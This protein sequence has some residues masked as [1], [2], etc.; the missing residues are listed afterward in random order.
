MHI[1]VTCRNE[2]NSVVTI[3]SEFLRIILDLA[4]KE[5]LGST[6]PN[7]SINQKRQPFLFNSFIPEQLILGRCR[8][9]GEQKNKK[10]LTT[11]VKKTQIG[12]ELYR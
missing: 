6:C 8:T 4:N 1:V 9:L 3:T 5:T 7:R 11:T 12:Y 2:T 10:G